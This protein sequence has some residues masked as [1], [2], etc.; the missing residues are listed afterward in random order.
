MDKQEIIAAIKQTASE[1]HG[2]PLGM[3]K[4]AK[5][6]GI[7]VHIWRGRYWHRWNDALMEAGF[8]K[9]ELSKAYDD[10][11]MIES[12]ISLIRKIK[13]FPI[14]S[15]FRMEKCTNS[16][17]PGYEAIRR[18]G[19][20]EKQVYLVRQF[21][22]ENSGFSDVLELL[23]VKNTTIDSSEFEFSNSEEKTDGFVYIVKEQ[24][25][26]HY[27][28]GKTF[29][30]PRRHREI[31]LEL[32]GELKKVHSIRTDDPS[33]IE[34]YW[35]KRFEDKRVKG[36]WFALASSDIKAFKRRKFM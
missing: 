16:A 34:A 21:C 24:F 29:D 33:G 23:P 6:T 22:N 36:E 19:N 15:E 17:F 25:S 10:L 5:I 3:E 18:L 30:V 31:N 11:F 14:S 9:N 1:N 4:F 27:K 20:K 12:L 26:K 13:H 8:E 28:I 32:P 7:S 2:K 35:H